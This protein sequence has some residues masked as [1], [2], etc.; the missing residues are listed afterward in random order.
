MQALIFDSVFNSYRGIEV[1]F[2]VKNGVIRK[3]DHVKFVNTGKN[4]EADEIGT[5]KLKH[6]PV[7]EIG[8]GN[9]GYLI[10]GI[11]KAKEIKVG[12]TNTQYQKKIK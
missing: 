11:K 12:E 1:F 10:S 4:Y 8:T 7:K 2:R 6:M 3:G 5:L 9:V